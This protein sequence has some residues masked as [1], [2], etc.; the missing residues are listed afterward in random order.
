MVQIDVDDAMDRLTCMS[1]EIIL[2][3]MNKILRDSQKKD[4][5]LLRALIPLVRSLKSLEQ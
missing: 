1:N 4:K 2:N 3:P 5:A